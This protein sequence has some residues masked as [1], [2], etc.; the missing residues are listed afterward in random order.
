MAA[1]IDEKLSKFKDLVSEIVTFSDTC[2]DFLLQTPTHILSF[3]LDRNGSIALLYLD[4]LCIYVKVLW[5]FAA[6]EDKKMLVAVAEAASF[7][8][9]SKAP[10]SR[11]NAPSKMER[12][13]SAMASY[14]DR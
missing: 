5:I 13:T 3:K 1:T 4:L 14:A 12:R 9:S 2:K 6:L 11:E 10:V 7:C 8:A